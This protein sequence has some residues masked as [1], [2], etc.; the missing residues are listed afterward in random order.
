MFEEKQSKIPLSNF[1]AMLTNVIEQGNQ[2]DLMHLLEHFPSYLA[3]IEDMG[4]L[5]TVQTSYLFL[6]KKLEMIGYASLLEDLNTTNNTAALVKHVIRLSKNTIEE[7]L[8]QL[9]TQLIG[10][11]LD[12]SAFSKLHSRIGAYENNVWLR[13]INSFKDNINNQL[14]LSI[15]SSGS[16]FTL[17][18]DN[19]YIVS[20][21]RDKMIQVWDI[22]TGLLVT[23]TD[24]PKFTKIESLLELRNNKR[25]YNFGRKREEIDQSKHVISRLLFNE[26]ENNLESE[27]PIPLSEN[28]ETFLAKSP[29][30]FVNLEDGDKTIGNTFLISFTDDNQDPSLSSLEGDALDAIMDELADEFDEYVKQSDWYQDSLEELY[31]TSYLEFG[32]GYGTDDEY[33]MRNS[34]K[35]QLLRAFLSDV[36]IGIRELD[37]YLDIFED[38]L[39]EIYSIQLIDPTTKKV[40]KELQGHTDSIIFVH[41]TLHPR[42]LISGSTDDSIRIWDIEDSVEIDRFEWE[43]DSWGYVFNQGLFAYSKDGNFIFIEDTYREIHKVEVETGKTIATFNAGSTQT[44]IT[45]LQNNWI[46]VGGDDGKIQIFNTASESK[47]LSL[48]GHTS[49]VT[50]IF[51]IPESQ[52]LIT[53][54][55]DGVIKVWNLS[56]NSN[57]STFGHIGEVTSLFIKEDKKFAI[58]GSSR[59]ELFI[60]DIS[61]GKINTKLELHNNEITT[62][63]ENA[64]ANYIVTGSNDGIFA[65]WDSNSFNLLF[66]S[67]D[68]K[69]K[70]PSIESIFSSKQGDIIYIGDG[71]SFQFIDIKI[72]KVLFNL[73]SSL[74]PTVNSFS[75]EEV[76]REGGLAKLAYDN[77]VSS[78]FVLDIDGPLLYL[79]SDSLSALHQKVSEDSRH[80]GMVTFEPNITCIIKTSDIIRPPIPRGFGTKKTINKNAGDTKSNREQLLN[81][82]FPFTY[83]EEMFINYFNTYEIHGALLNK[84]SFIDSNKN[85]ITLDGHEGAITVVSLT[86][87]FKYI[88]SAGYDNQIIVWDRKTGKRLET[89]TGHAA[90]ITYIHF[91]DTFMVSQSEDDEYILWDLES[92]GLVG[93]I[94]STI[95]E[96]NKEIGTRPLIS[97]DKNRIRVRANPAAPEI[98]RAI[99][100]SEIIHAEFVDELNRLIVT[101]ENGEVL[102]FRVENFDVNRLNTREM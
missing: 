15:P 47:V 14:L 36:G 41:Q 21:I 57:D 40:I 34:V 30:L 5:E 7:D 45:E 73:R 35:D 71:N 38:E 10:R 84:I 77:L 23:E 31:E 61:T 87:D 26:I 70:L 72:Q 101:C 82:V 66:S 94:E 28:N 18:V 12:S 8:S 97:V 52:I 63:H 75:S 37:D 54:S 92:W 90:T 96:K 102:F 16:T 59:G 86:Q 81:E 53:G 91:N 76:R 43:S 11:S 88:I 67:K 74:A 80:K 48:D 39:L 56:R 78:Y 27:A 62:I 17:S 20:G 2:E 58:S 68:I 100:D 65:L 55:L 50:S 6:K 93:K 60:W 95:V 64:N 69:T 85:K 98:T 89:L 49:A 42:Y 9:P 25:F 51:E 79:M 3:E 83:T 22:E 24:N 4:E 29:Q 1:E 99:L 32:S 13:P 46:A 19:K 44:A 33:N